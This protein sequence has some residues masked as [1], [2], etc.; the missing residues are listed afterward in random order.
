MIVTQIAFIDA[1]IGN[2]SFP[3]VR[4]LRNVIG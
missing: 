2:S 4:V 3:G 1:T